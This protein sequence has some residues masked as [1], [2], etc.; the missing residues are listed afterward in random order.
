MLPKRR[1]RSSLDKWYND[2]EH[3]LSFFDYETEI[4]LKYVEGYTRIL[5]TQYAKLFPK[6]R[7]TK[8]KI[9]RVVKASRLHDI[10]KLAVPEWI[11]LKDGRMSEGEFDILKTHTI[12]GCEMVQ[13]LGQTNDEEYNRICRNIVLYH[14][15]RYDGS[16]Y[17]YG[18]KK[19]KIPLEA[20]IVALADI[21]DILI[22]GGGER[23]RFTK[24]E[25]F[26]MIIRDDFG[27]ISPRLR[28][29]IVVAKEVLELFEVE[30]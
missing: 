3:A 13:L 2:E 23:K 12:K 28:E 30:E 17:P 1:Q 26:Q 6:S 15:E 8:D 19:D 21:Y 11:L 9:E 25:A 27:Q 4:H 18:L 5:A 16:G 10:G 24:D 14:H 22:H 20:Q 29:C 7:M